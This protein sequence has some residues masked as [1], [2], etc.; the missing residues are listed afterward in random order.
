MWKEQYSYLDLA[1]AR[2]Q[3]VPIFSRPAERT[4]TWL[5]SPP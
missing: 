2:L 4:S 1:L 5:A 3:A